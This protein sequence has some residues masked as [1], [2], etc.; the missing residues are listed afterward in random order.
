MI[1]HILDNLNEKLSINDDD[2]FTNIDAKILDTRYYQPNEFIK[3][4]G[5]CQFAILNINIRSMTK[6]F[7]NFLE[8]YKDIN[9]YFD[10]ICIT[11][12]WEDKEAPLS[13]NSLFNLPHYKLVSRPRTS[14]KGGGVC[15]YVLNKHSFEI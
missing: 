14:S 1:S 2:T 11:E 10:V 12:T 8:F 6:N 4:K 9:F 15:I 13:N 3:I 5:E 7:S